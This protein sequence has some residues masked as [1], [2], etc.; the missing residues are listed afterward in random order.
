M[1]VVLGKKHREESRS[2]EEEM[3]RRC[4]HAPVGRSRWRRASGGRAGAVGWWPEAS[5]KKRE[6]WRRVKF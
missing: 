6:I 1:D 5:R 4:G 3:R 2:G